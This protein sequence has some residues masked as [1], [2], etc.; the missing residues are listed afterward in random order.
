MHFYFYLV[1]T[2]GVNPFLPI[3]YLQRKKIFLKPS[4]SWHKIVRLMVSLGLC[5]FFFFSCQQNQVLYTT[6]HNRCSIDAVIY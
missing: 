4:L 6:D 3:L 5:F 1:F 2:A